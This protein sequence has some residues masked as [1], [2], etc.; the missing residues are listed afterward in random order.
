MCEHAPSS[1]S[2]CEQLRRDRC[3]GVESDLVKSV[4]MLLQAGADVNS[5]EGRDV[6]ELN[7]I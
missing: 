3:F 7:L 6:L 1:R 4:N 5:S 2:R